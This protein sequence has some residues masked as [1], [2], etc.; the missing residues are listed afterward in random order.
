MKHPMLDRS[1][2]DLVAE[3][4][5][6]DIVRQRLLGAD[7]NDSLGRF[8]LRGT[9]GRGA[10]GRVYA[11]YDPLLERDVALKL[12]VSPERQ[13]LDRG[14]LEARALAKVR[15]P[16][17]VQLFEVIRQDD[18]LGLVMERV[19]GV[20]LDVWVATGPSEAALSRLFE[21]LAE[22]LAVI[23]EAGLVHRD[24]KPANV[25]VDRKGTP[26]LVDFGLV[27]HHEPR[28][29][30]RRSGT[31]RYMAPEQVRGIGVGPW[32]DQYA[33]AVIFEA[34]LPRPSAGLR[35]I[36]R[37]A[38]SH[39]PAE[40]YPDMRS[41]LRALRRLRTGRRVA[42]F[43]SLGVLLCIS[44]LLGTPADDA[45]E[46][47]VGK[48]GSWTPQSSDA[49]E[50]KLSRLKAPVAEET[51]ARVTS[52]LDALHDAFVD[53]QLAVCEQERSE[54][55]VDA[56]AC[57]VEYGATFEAT[58]DL[59]GR[60]DAP[61]L[62][63]ATSVVHML[64]HPSRCLTRPATAMPR[65]EAVS[66]WEIATTLGK[67]R[68][69]RESCAVTSPDACRASFDAAKRE[70]GHL[71]ACTVEPD[72]LYW[73]GLGLFEAH[74]PAGALESLMA[75]AWKAE[76]CGLTSVEFDAKR[77]T[78]ALLAFE[79]RHEASAFWL[80]AAQAAMERTSAD[81]YRTAMLELARGMALSDRDPGQSANHLRAGIDLLAPHAA[82]ARS[83]LAIA[84]VN[85]GQSLRKA[86]A[87]EAIAAFEEASRIQIDLHGSRAPQVASTL[88]SLAG[89]H[90]ALGRH[91]ESLRTLG[92]AASIYT[93]FEDALPVDRIQV[94]MNR[95]M[96]L[97]ELGRLGQAM[98]HQRVALEL[99]NRL[100]DPD[101]RMLLAIR[102][103]L[104]LTRAL[105][106][107]LDVAAEELE[108]LRSMASNR[109]PAFG[110]LE[111]ELTVNLGLLELRRARFERASRLL[112]GSARRSGSQPPAKTLARM[113]GCSVASVARGEFELAV[114]V[115]S[116]FEG[117]LPPALDSNSE[118]G[119]LRYALAKA[120]A[121]RGDLERARP[122]AR[123]ALAGFAD[124]PERTTEV[125]AWL[126]AHPSGGV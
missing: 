28:S 113:A 72:L 68:A 84:Y 1:H 37:R 70:L 110:P 79:A 112:C 125:R 78:G 42:R 63:K 90:L 98:K 77:L 12:I 123:R 33:W 104:A 43:A 2:A 3:R 106:G 23:H 61:A 35:S 10:H 24:V 108:V 75:A 105:E 107:E 119:E 71:P 124:D 49:L 21:E 60:L 109:D 111:E 82:T 101:P 59:L 76:G 36:L 66:S 11:A 16:N 122:L 126:D 81:D 58:V 88:V 34:A 100:P 57:L 93:I 118:A 29:D 46:P 115:A 120:Y 55:G 31:P 62:R 51:A 47:W 39:D 94:E 117:T 4:R 6:L 32:S 91:E 99:A 27:L 116:T 73:R 15:H 25:L 56:R 83:D 22:A 114:D 80:S 40:R 20:T 52:R 14:L 44:W 8:V 69:L 18:T 41:V 30:P 9:I 89:A 103:D 64:G 48:A 85:L 5:A 19:E 121:G 86:G 92:E 13:R 65:S 97:R 45:C 67:L 74:D 7:A 26:K 102:Q 53:A 54:P 96:V 95:G 17:L 50:R 38:R 87:P